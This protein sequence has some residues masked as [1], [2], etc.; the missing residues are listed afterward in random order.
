MKKLAVLIRLHKNRLNEARVH[1]AACDRVRA[2]LAATLA[3]LDRDM[4]SERAAAR[5][6][7]EAARTYPAF[8]RRM[9][10]ERARLEHSL[11]EADVA[12]D[13]AGELVAACFRE[14]KTVEQ[15][16]AAE[17]ERTRATEAR[18]DQAVLDEIG[19]DR[20]RRQGAGHGR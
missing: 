12:V 4:E 16:A 20:A 19:G 17:A 7:L 2:E 1:L 14:L 8:A 18:R 6:S 15:V 10:V 13:Q 5:R 3:R 11:G 9:S